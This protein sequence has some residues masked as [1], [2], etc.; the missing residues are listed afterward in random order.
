MIR[1][2]WILWTFPTGPFCPRHFGFPA[3]V[4]ISNPPRAYNCS[5]CCLPHF[6]SEC[7]KTCFHP[8]FKSPHQRENPWLLYLKQHLISSHTHSFSLPT[9]LSYFALFLSKTCFA[10][11]Y[12]PSL[13]L[14]CL[15]QPVNIEMSMMVAAL[16]VVFTVV[17]TEVKEVPGTCQ[18]SSGKLY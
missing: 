2:L 5:S 17:S 1:L 13:I 3:V 8:L 11:W 18:R 7:C 16:P 14:C 6:P 10:P 15:S 4:N 9:H 12:F